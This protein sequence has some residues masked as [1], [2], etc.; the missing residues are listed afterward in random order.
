[1]SAGASPKGRA[2]AAKH[3]DIAF[4]PLAE[5]DPQSIRERMDSYRRIAREQFGRDLRVWINAYVFQGDSEA[6]ARRRYD[7]CVHE[8]GDWE[9]VDNLVR[10]MGLSQQSHSPEMLIKLKEDFIA[11]WAGFRLLGTKEMIAEDMKML[12]EAGVDGILLTFPAFTRDMER[13]QEEVYP[14]LVQEGLR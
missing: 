4:S 1:M 2:F 3:C 8:K 6:D 13:F 10:Q 11:G 5:R 7:H 12:A 9:G 14:L